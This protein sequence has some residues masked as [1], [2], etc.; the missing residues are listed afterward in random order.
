MEIK[1]EAD[2]LGHL[3]SLP[4]TNALW[5]SF[6]VSFIL[7]VVAWKVRKNWQEVP[8]GKLQFFIEFLLEGAENFMDSIVQNRKLTRRLFPF[9]MTMFLFFLVSNLLAIIPG[10]LAIKFNGIHFFRPPTTDYNAVLVISGV[11]FLLMQITAFTS[12]GP[13]KYFKKY[14]NYSSPINFLVSLIEALGDVARVVAMSFRLFGNMVA[15]EVLTAVVV[16]LIPFI[17]PIPFSLL[18]LII[19][20]VQPAVFAILSLIF[21]KLSIIEEHGH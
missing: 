19:A 7:I 9:I 14:I 11:T 15:E 8:T 2:T 4:I 1:I 12:G 16:A 21:I 18:G 6:L 3:Y 20:V 13:L 10:I 5:V 17:V